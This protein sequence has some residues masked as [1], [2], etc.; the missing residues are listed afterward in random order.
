[1][2]AQHALP[3]PSSS[4]SLQ[5]PPPPAPVW[6]PSKTPPIGEVRTDGTAYAIYLPLGARDWAPWRLLGS[7]NNSGQPVTHAA[8]HDPE[9]HVLTTLPELASTGSREP[10]APT[11]AAA[12]QPSHSEARVFYSNDTQPDDVAAVVTPDGQVW[13]RSDWHDPGAWMPWD[14]LLATYGGAVEVPIEALLQRGYADQQ[15]RAA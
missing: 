3:A 2:A 10:A 5:Q 13:P 7:P 15:S 1:M 14:E 9:W 8:V 12:E 6:Q 11:P 4:A